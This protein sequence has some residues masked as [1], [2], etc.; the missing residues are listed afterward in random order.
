[1]VHVD[2]DEVEV[3]SLILVQPGEK[4]PIDG[5]VVEQISGIPPQVQNEAL[6]SARRRL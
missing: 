6:P 3:G 1:M 4:I 2:P 5:V